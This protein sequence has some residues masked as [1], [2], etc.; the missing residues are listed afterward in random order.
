MI[1]RFGFRLG[2][3]RPPG[4]KG[5]DMPNLGFV[6]PSSDL[7]YDILDF[8]QSIRSCHLMSLL[9]S[10]PMYATWKFSD[11]RTY[12]LEIARDINPS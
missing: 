10:H 5:T 11:Y 3:R 1:G 6:L 7:Q 2:V 8:D 12:I 4:E 9:V